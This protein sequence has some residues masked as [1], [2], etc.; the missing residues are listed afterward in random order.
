MDITFLMF[1]DIFQTQ[2]DVLLRKRIRTHT[3]SS[4]RE[5][6][7]AGR[8]ANKYFELKEDSA[9]GRKPSVFCAIDNGYYCVFA[10]NGPMLD[11]FIKSGELQNYSGFN[12]KPKFPGDPNYRKSLLRYTSFD[13]CF[14]FLNTDV[15]DREL[16]K[17]S[18]YKYLLRNNLCHRPQ[19]VCKYVHSQ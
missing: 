13:Q 2:E 1:L 7:S 8:L 4:V 14:N 6:I 11:S 18:I 19:N 12:V 9:R 3:E 10:G 17:T 16:F 5:I 15:D